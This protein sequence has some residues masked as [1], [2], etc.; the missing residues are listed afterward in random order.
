MYVVDFV[1]FPSD[2]TAASGRF[3]QEAFG[4][5]PTEYGPTY[6]DIGGAGVGL[7]FQA[8]P[9]DQTAAPLVAIRTDDLEAARTAVETAG[10]AITLEPFAFPGGRRF[11]FR[12]PGG[13]ELAVW[14]PAD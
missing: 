6:S 1:E 2:S 8:D 12:E 5:T 7:G 13:S 3:F 14:Q 9:K 10:G 11:H 4:W